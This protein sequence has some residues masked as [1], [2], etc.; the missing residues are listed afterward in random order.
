MVSSSAGG[1]R[2]DHTENNKAENRKK[3]MLRVFKHF[4][5]PR[6][7]DSEADQDE[8]SELSGEREVSVHKKS[9]VRRRHYSFV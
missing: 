3:I 1:H 7:S 9:D 4:G 5:G 6:I 2:S 8:G